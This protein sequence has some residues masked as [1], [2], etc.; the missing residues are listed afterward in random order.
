MCEIGACSGIVRNMTGTAIRSG[1]PVKM[2][3]RKRRRTAIW[4]RAVPVAMALTLSSIASAE[5][6]PAIG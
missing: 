2:Q 5:D 1:V 4:A 3:H 6:D